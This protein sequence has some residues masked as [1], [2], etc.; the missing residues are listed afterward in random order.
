MSAER[1]LG[2]VRQAP[3]PLNTPLGATVKYNPHLWGDDELRAI[4]VVRQPELAAL[5]D[6]VRRTP[7]T[8]MPQHRLIVGQRGMGKTTLLRRLALAIRDDAELSRDWLALT[9][10]EEQYTVSTLGELWRNVLDALADALEDGGAPAAELAALDKTI[11]D[12]DDLPLAQR[13]DAALALLIDWIARQQRRV[14]LLIDSSDLLFATLAGNSKAHAD[15]RGLRVGDADATPLWRLRRTLTHQPGLFWIGASYQA[16][17]AERAYDAAFHDFFQL[18]ELRPLNSEQMRQALLAL[19]RTFGFDGQQGDAAAA[20]M[21]QRLDARPERLQALRTMTGGNP[22]TTVILFDLFAANADGNVHSDLRGLLD[23]MTPLYKARMEALAD[24]PRK[25]LAH[26]MEAW[27]P[28]TAGEL[29]AAAGLPV[30]T[31]SGQLSR[32]ES[33]GLIEKVRLPGRRRNGYQAGERF[34]NVWYL[35][36]LASRRLRQRLSWLIEFMRL[37]FSTPERLGLAQARAER[38]W[39]G[40][41]NDDASLEYSRALAGTLPAEHAQRCR[42]EWSVF[43]AARQNARAALGELFDLDGT[44]REFATADDY[45]QRFAALD[46]RLQRCPQVGAEEMAAW[47]EA[48]KGSLSLS[49]AEKERV[50]DAAPSLSR[51]Q[52]DALRKFLADEFSDCHAHF[53]VAALAVVRRATLDGQFFPDCPDAKLSYTQ[54]QAAFG[55]NPAAYLFGLALFSNR[56]S[57]TWVEKAYRRAIELDATLAWPWNNLGNLL[58][59][60]LQRY[61][62]AEAAYRR[63]IELDATNALPWDNL[64]NL[65]TNHLQRYTEAEA[66]YRRAIELDATRASPWNNLANLLCDHLQ[67]YAEAEAAYRRAIELDAT[68]A[69]PWNNLGTLLQDHLQRYAEAEA[70]YRRAMAID[71]AEPYPVVNLARLLASQGRN[72]EAAG[73]YRQAVPLAE[74]SLHRVGSSSDDLAMIL[75]AQLWLGNRDAAEQAFTELAKYAA[76]GDAHAFSR[77]REQ[78][79]ACRTLGLGAALARLIDDSAYADFLQPLSLALREA[80]GEDALDVAPA[81]V[82]A[83]A[84]E[85]RAAIDAGQAAPNVRR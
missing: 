10:P 71:E 14:V 68:D 84:G 79:T 31:V 37:W 66:A 16:L 52:V 41:I 67:R 33:D 58:A 24:Q 50:A 83:L 42:L 82:A 1:S 73:L 77:L 2:S 8:S 70:A 39:H 60:H 23:L 78:V 80:S 44:E 46:A 45:L 47:V 65:L 27:A 9:F 74:K 25:L 75:Q 56:H 64:G 5:L 48:V 69:R 28:Q 34:F 17:E 3:A 62:E 20:A 4:F 63:A 40:Q 15:G 35:M 55:D 38:H 7:A 85:V 13:E 61:A 43:T 49:L 32:L 12:I 26:L 72:D 30:T 29:A 22:R 76:Q 59:N 36:R 11:A 21:A 19:A 6:A 51:F 81:E 53:P 57:D 18:V 54:L